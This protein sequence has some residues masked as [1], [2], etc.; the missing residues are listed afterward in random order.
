M[1]FLWSF[2]GFKGAR[3][4]KRVAQSFPKCLHML[5]AIWS[6]SGGQTGS[7]VTG[8]RKRR[9]SDFLLGEMEVRVALTGKRK[10]KRERRRQSGGRRDETFG[11]ECEE[12]RGGGGG[13]REGEGGVRLG[14]LLVSPSVA[15]ICTS[16]SRMLAQRISGRI[17][18]L[19]QTHTCTHTQTDTH[20]WEHSVQVGACV[21]GEGSETKKQNKTKH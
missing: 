7:I 12:S 20:C 13:G 11:G 5:G 2:S 14:V 4:T 21:N 10:Q 15:G 1:A 3:A 9:K 18:T 19:Q 6:L 16:P 8:A 17:R